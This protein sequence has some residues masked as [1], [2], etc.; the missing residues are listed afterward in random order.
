MPDLPSVFA[1]LAKRSAGMCLA[2]LN[3][4]QRAE[5]LYQLFA[6]GEPIKRDGWRVGSA[7]RTAR[8]CSCSM[9]ASPPSDGNRGKTSRWLLSA[10]RG[11]G[12]TEILIATQVA[13]QSPPR[14][15]LHRHRPCSDRPD[16]HRAGRLW[17]HEGG[18]RPLPEPCFLVAGLAGDE[19]PAFG[20]PLWWDSVYRGDLLLRTW[21]LLCARRELTLPDEIDELVQ[22]VY[23]E[24]VDIPGPLQERLDAEIENADGKVFAFKGQANM[25]IIGLPDDASWNDSARFVLYDDDEPGVHQTLKA[26]TRL[27]D[28]SVAAVPIFPEDTFDPQRQPDFAQARRLFLAPRI[29]RA[30]GVVKKL[31]RSAFRRDGGSRHCCETATPGFL[32]RWVAGWKIVPCGWMRIWEWFM[33]RGKLNEPFQPD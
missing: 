7:C 22:A 1:E 16:L 11:N 29:C 33:K 8:K 14:L 10:R 2:L 12:W 3:M 26:K 6:H 18:P 9:C 15:R 5:E 27:G 20:K 17:R 30:W 31:N 25:A 13:E 24:Q 32:T 19:L 4:A 28:D 21:C 23:E